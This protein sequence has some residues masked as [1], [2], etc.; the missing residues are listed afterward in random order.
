MVVLAE[1]GVVFLVKRALE[2]Y[3]EHISCYFYGSPIFFNANPFIP[4][5]LDGFLRHTIKIFAAV[6]VV[7]SSF[8]N[9]QNNRFGA[10]DIILSISLYENMLVVSLVPCPLTA[11]GNCN[12]AIRSFLNISQILPASSNYKS[13][14]VGA[15]M[16]GFWKINFFGE[17][18]IF[19]ISVIRFSEV[20]V[21]VLV[22]AGAVVASSVV[23]NS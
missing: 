10:V 16:C 12:L 3:Q 20:A 5:L 14:V 7:R 9:V 19:I 23:R 6:D 13:R 2:R 17:K 15:L 1:I 21:V 22:L 18:A 11:P 8:E 4:Q